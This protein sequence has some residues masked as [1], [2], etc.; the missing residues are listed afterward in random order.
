MSPQTG[1]APQTKL[2]TGEGEQVQRIRLEAAD[3]GVVC[4]DCNL[5]K[6]T[7]TVWNFHS[8]ASWTQRA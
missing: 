1:P 2:T 7:R 6:R 4:F 8:P 5:K 3:G